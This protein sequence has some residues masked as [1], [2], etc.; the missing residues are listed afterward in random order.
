MAD[1]LTVGAEATA[2]VGSVTDPDF[3]ERFIQTAVD[4]VAGID[5]MATILVTSGTRLSRR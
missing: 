1:I 2:C 5:F 3:A 4:N